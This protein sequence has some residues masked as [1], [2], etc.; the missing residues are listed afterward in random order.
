MGRVLWFLVVTTLVVVVAWWVAFLPGRVSASAFGYSVEAATPI[1][2]VAV[3]VAVLLLHWVLRLFSGFVNLPERIGFWRG[4]RQRRAGDAAVGRALVALA[5]GDV[6]VSRRQ[7]LRARA[8]LGD[9]PQTLLLA[10][11]SARLA[12]DPERAKALYQQMAQR[13]D[14][15]FLGLRGLFRQAV[16]REDWAEAANLA[17]QAEALQPGG[18][19]L[20][21]ARLRLAEET[22]DWT[23]A[24]SLAGPDLPEEVL[25][26]A[27]A[28][29][30]ADPDAAGRLARRAWKANPSFAPAAVAYAGILR[31]RG[32]ER[33]AAAV[34]REAWRTAP[35]PDLAKF[36]LANI[37]DSKARLSA[38][39]MLTKANLDHAES[40]FL[41]A[42]LALDAGDVGEARHNAERSLGMASGT[43]RLFLLMADIAVAEGKDPAPALRDAAMAE[44]DAGWR[45]DSCGTSQTQWH[46]VCPTCH[47]PARIGWGRP[48]A[49]PRLLTAAG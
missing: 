11:E 7:S 44:P 4:R 5:A 42:R 35:H 40:R 48:T 46:A 26:T 9:T 19:W 29:T 34:I 39:Q 38:A 47:T 6:A 27:A 33:R 8:L 36:M 14:G 45:C 37:S 16:E 43:R 15:A 49:G 20:R 1:A 25:A 23:R 30:T 22:G 24:L 18:N 31:R 3:V 10:A 2:A 41:L 17:R 13:P 12:G 32:N 28:A 21:E